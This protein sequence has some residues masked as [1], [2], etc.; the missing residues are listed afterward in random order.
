M[1]TPRAVGAVLAWVAAVAAATAVAMVAIGAIGSGIVDQGPRPL[2]QGEVAASLSAAPPIPTTAQTTPSDTP[3]GAPGATSA[4][5]ATTE[6]AAEPQPQPRA[7]TSPGGTV[8][9]RCTP[10]V[11]IVS[12]TPAQGYGVES[13]EPEDG[14]TR[15]RFRSGGHGRGD[16]RVEV[17]VRCTDGQPTATVETDS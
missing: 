1:N 12:T 14:S 17:Y 6:P 7:L 4:T 15:V 3:T 16:G 13:V 11:E 10:G 8:L 2:S 5:S 9:A